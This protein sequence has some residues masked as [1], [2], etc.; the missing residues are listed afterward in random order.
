MKNINSFATPW[1]DK[2]IS[3][4]V[5]NNFL[6]NFFIKIFFKKWILNNN[7]NISYCIEINFK[8]ANNQKTIN[9]PLYDYSR[10][11]TH[12][13]IITTISKSNLLRAIFRSFY[14]IINKNASVVGIP[15][16]YMAL[17]RNSIIEPIEYINY[18]NGWRLIHA[19]VFSINGKVFIVSAGSKV[20]KSTLVTTLINKH[21]GEILSDNYCFVKGNMVRTI[22]EPIR[23]GLPSNYRISFYKRTISGYPS[24]YEGRIDTFIILKRG[25]KN[26]LTEIN[27]KD[28]NQFIDT[29]NHN[30]KEGVFFLDI[31]D[32]I[33][34]NKNKLFIKGDFTTFEL[35]VKE[36][37]E[38]I[39]KSIEILKKI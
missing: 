24:S 10:L 21:K 26:K 3:I 7:S 8:K 19:S 39:D 23:G 16:L 18:I 35:E 6:Y 20:G 4:I 17:I 14:K 22:E 34:I 30:E 36:G 31:N 27:F 1:S 29:T 37:I 12:D 9:T 32:Q 2:N 28:V 25:V 11:R 33:R 5:N 38:N 13:K 15:E